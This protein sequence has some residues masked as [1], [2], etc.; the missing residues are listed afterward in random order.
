MKTTREKSQKIWEPIA[1]AFLEP[2]KKRKNVLGALLVGSYAVGMETPGSDIDI[3]IILTDDSRYWERGNVVISGFL[4]EYAIYPRSYLTSLQKRDLNDKKRLRTRML[5]T[6]KILFDRIGAIKR[7]QTQAHSLIEKELP[8]QNQKAVE[9]RKY[10]L[11]DQLDN[12]QEVKRL[13]WEGFAYAY[14]SA[15]QSVLEFYAD[16]LR[17]EIPRP[18]CIFRFLNSRN[19][20]NRYCINVIR[21][22]KFSRLFVDAMRRQSL[23]TLETL[24]AHVLSQA[25]GFA[26]DGWKIRGRSQ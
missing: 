24:T 17:V 5:A 13:Q 10:M 2:W 9:L 23:K 21:D 22:K 25:G 7:L 19:F 14:Y 16:F 1:T 12:L 15:L 6:G 4:V 26:I 8:K 11:W 18:T 20:Q 3:C